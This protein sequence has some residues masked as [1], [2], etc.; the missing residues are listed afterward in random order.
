MVFFFFCQHFIRIHLSFSV[1][2]NF[3]IFQFAVL[4]CGVS[5]YIVHDLLAYPEV[6]PLTLAMLVFTSTSFSK[7]QTLNYTPDLNL[8]F[9]LSAKINSHT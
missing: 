9:L 8:E 1:Q 2:V 7:P 6:T 5:V 4:S 3:S